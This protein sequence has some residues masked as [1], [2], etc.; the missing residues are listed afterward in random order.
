MTPVVR[1]ILVKIIVAIDISYI[2]YCIVSYI[3]KELNE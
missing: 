2:L 3:R 1:E